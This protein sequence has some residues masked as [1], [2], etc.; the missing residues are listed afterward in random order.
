MWSQHLRW[1]AKQ[2]KPPRSPRWWSQLSICTLDQILDMITAT[3]S[4]K[5]DMIAFH[6]LL[7]MLLFHIVNTRSLTRG[8]DKLLRFLTNQLVLGWHL[9]TN[10]DCYY[11]HKRPK[12]KMPYK[13]NCMILAPEL[14]TKKQKANEPQVWTQ[15]ESFLMF[16]IVCLAH[17]DSQIYSLF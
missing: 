9:F 4:W 1:D 8:M 10:L 13:N 16:V 7:L 3:Y 17:G 5:R 14:K 12:R 15:P 6:L 11:E 2:N